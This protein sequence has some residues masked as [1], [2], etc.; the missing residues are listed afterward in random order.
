MNETTDTKPK[1]AKTKRSHRE[2]S[3]QRLTH[4]QR[5]WLDHYLKG[6]TAKDAALAA[7]Y[8]A[9]STKSQTFDL[10]NHPLIKAELARVEAL[11]RQQTAFDCV[12]AFNEQGRIMELAIANNHFSAAQKASEMRA[13]LHGLLI[14]RSQMELEVNNRVDIKGAL[15]AARARVVNLSLP[16]PKP[17]NVLPACD[18][19]QVED[20]QVIDVKAALGAARNDGPSIPDAGS[21]VTAWQ[22]VD[23]NR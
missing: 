2:G 8:S 4:R 3:G 1:K 13:R 7:G 6:A 16:A 21:R 18:L 14:D 19:A 9:G 11:V 20:A 12:A 10:L 23:L 17:A 5:A 15:D 22:R